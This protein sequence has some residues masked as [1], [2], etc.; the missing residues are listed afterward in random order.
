MSNGIE[1]LCSEHG[2]YVPQ[3]MAWRLYDAGWTINPDDVSV[4]DA[5]PDDFVYWET[6]AHILEHAEYTDENGYVW[7]LYHDGDLWAVCEKLMSDEEKYNF[8]GEY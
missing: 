2:Q 5:G 8:F 6:W 7:R 4:C 1:L 3:T